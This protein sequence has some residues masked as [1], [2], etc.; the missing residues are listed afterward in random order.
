VGEVA[1]LFFLH[2]LQEYQKG[3]LGLNPQPKIA[4]SLQASYQPIS[5]G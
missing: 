4:A 3:R 2:A 1:T 5:Q